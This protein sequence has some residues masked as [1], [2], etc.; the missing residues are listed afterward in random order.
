MRN[1]FRLT[2]SLALGALLVAL[3]QWTRDV[4]ALARL[5]ASE[6][7]TTAACDQAEFD[8]R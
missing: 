7:T 2:L 8:Q 6:S 5:R 4:V 3:C 1:L